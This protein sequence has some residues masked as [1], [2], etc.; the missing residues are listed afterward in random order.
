MWCSPRIL[1]GKAAPNSFNDTIV[2]MIPKVNSPELLSQFRPVHFCNVLY[3]IASKVIANR[4]KVIL[5]DIISEDQSAFVPGRLISD[6]IISAYECL[7]FMKRNRSKTN[8]S[9]ALKLDMLKAYDRLEWN[10]LQAIMLKLGFSSAWVDIIMGMVKSVSFSVLLNGEKL[11]QFKPS[12]GIRQGDPISPYLFLLAAEGLSCLLK[13]S[14]QSSAFVGI[15]VAPTAPTVSHLLFADDSLLL[16]K[17]SVEGAELVSNLLGTY[18]GAS[19]QRINHVKSSVF[20]SRG[21]PDSLKQ[22]VMQRLNVHNESLSDRYLGM[23]T[24]V[25]HSKMGTFKYLSDRVW[26]KVKGWMSKCLSAGGKDVL[27]KSVAHAIPVYSMSCF[28]L[29]RGLCNHLNSIIRKFWWGSK[30]GRRKPCWV[31]WD[32]MTRP[33][34]LGGLGF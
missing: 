18:C 9:C 25:G 5:P 28:K 24:D 32:V 3:K 31:S 11:E 22:G 20:F 21:C 15:K 14:S 10:Y 7:H 33:K 8:N 34:D 17:S 29:L 27:I 13:S 6:N 1:G 19:G 2:V 4:L 26:D 12:R 23:P 30:Q 16:F